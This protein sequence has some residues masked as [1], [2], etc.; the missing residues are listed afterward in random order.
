MIKRTLYF[1]NPAYLRL[2]D[3]QLQVEIKTEE[4]TK[5]STIPVEIWEL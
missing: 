2:E 4:E 5:I 3:K 1:G